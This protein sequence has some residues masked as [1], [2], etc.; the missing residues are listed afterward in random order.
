MNIYFAE[1]KSCFPSNA[2]VK[3]ENGKSITM[4]E[5]QIGDQIQ[6]GISFFY[7]YVSGNNQYNYYCFNIVR[8]YKPLFWMVVT[9]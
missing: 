2:N 8:I 3:L 5:L 7:L 9:F 1:K 6:T 4:S